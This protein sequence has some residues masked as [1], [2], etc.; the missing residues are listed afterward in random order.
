MGCLGPKL[1][2]GMVMTHF[3][4]LWTGVTP[5]A[6]FKDRICI[7]LFF[8][9]SLFF[10]ALSISLIFSWRRAD[11]QERERTQEREKKRGT[12]EGGALLAI[13]QGASTPRARAR[14]PRHGE[15][16]ASPSPSLG[17]AVPSSVQPWPGS[18]LLGS[19]PAKKS[20]GW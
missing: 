3:K 17:A 11:R 2:L 14:S 5:H 4:S 9:S 18:D 19:G 16:P 13:G 1:S 8:F 7:L 20:R 15:V 6:K 10:L 12:Q